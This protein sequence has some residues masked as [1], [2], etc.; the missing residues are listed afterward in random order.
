M[1]EMFI[2]RA[3]L[4][5]KLVLRGKVSEWP[6]KVCVNALLLRVAREKFATLSATK[7]VD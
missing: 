2:E 6:E 7:S 5:L 4:G 1:I 3:I